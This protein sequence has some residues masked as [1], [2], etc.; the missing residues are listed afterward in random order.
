LNSVFPRPVGDFSY[1]GYKACR[2]ME[3]GMLENNHERAAHLHM[4]AAQAHAAAA[5]AHRRYDYEK[6]GELSSTAQ[7]FS[8]TAAEKT[9]EIEKEMSE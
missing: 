5:S 1:Q 7:I 4:Y 9:E 3:V 6:A 8:S 2:I